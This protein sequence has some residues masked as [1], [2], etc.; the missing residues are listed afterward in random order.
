MLASLRPHRRSNLHNNNRSRF[1]DLVSLSANH[2]RLQAFSQ[3]LASMLLVLVLLTLLLA[4]TFEQLA[5]VL[6]QL[7]VLPL[8]VL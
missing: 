6:L 4:L 8:F 2:R 7:L 5:R 1:L 3:Q